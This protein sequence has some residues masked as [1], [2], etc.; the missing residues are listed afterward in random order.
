LTL[1]ACNTVIGYNLWLYGQ[2]GH[3][4]VAVRLPT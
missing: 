1:G 3:R 2:A 4:P